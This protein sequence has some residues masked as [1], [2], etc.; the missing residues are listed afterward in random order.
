METG[1]LGPSSAQ[2]GAPTA[3]RAEA[4]GHRLSGVQGLPIQRSPLKRFR[5]W[6]GRR[7]GP[8]IGKSGREGRDARDRANAP[9]TLNFDHV[10]TS[11]SSTDSLDSL[12]D[13]RVPEHFGAK[14]YKL[15]DPSASG[16]QAHQRWGRAYKH[17]RMYH[18]TYEENIESIKKT[19]LDPSYGGGGLS[20]MSGFNNDISYNKNTV[21]LSRVYEGEHQQNYGRLIRMRPFL[22][23]KRTVMHWE[24]EK[25]AP[26]H[27]LEMD[28]EHRG[29]GWITRKKIKPQHINFG[30]NA[31][32]LNNDELFEPIADKIASH[33]GTYAPQ[34]LEE[35]KRLHAEA[36]KSG[37][38]SE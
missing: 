25:K 3:A 9:V 14:H 36:R 4:L 5:R 11:S 30:T 32:L 34:N 23:N 28:K 29:V 19:G 37:Y 8:V 7:G 38:I 21:H 35:A 27:Q 1:A 2:A 31:E 6:M 17:A 13:T 10:L 12:E 15:Q 16:L 22:S 18:N 26:A 33:M 20:E 24:S